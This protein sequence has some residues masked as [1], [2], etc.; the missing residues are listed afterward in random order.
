MI[1][2]RL[3]VHDAYVEIYVPEKEYSKLLKWANRNEIDVYKL[4]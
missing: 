3:W 2:V 1:K 4:N